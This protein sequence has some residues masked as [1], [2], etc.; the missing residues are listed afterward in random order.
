MVQ[1]LN[2]LGHDSVVRRDH[3]DCDVRNLCT[4]RT[5][6][7]EGLVT[8]GVDK[9]DSP[10]NSLVLGPHLV[11]ADVLGDPASFSGGDVGIS[12]GIEQLGLTVVDVTHD[13]HDRRTNHQVGFVFHLVEVNVEAFQELFIFVFRRDDLHLVAQLGTEDFEGRFVERLRCCGHFAKLEQNR[14][15]VAGGNRETR[16]CFNL[17]GKIAHGGALAQADDG[18]TVTARDGYAA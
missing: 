6:G 4:S 17:V 13:R 11:G 5:H 1:S 18:R 10:F 7:R 12:N 15:Q 9:R 14:D 2:R 8:G 3:Q 16:Q